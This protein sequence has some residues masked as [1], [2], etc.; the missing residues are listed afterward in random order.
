MAEAVEETKPPATVSVCFVVRNE[1][2]NLPRALAAVQGMADEVLVL[3]TGSCDATIEVARRHGARV[4][5]HLW[6]DD[7]AA[8]KNAAILEASSEWV[9]L[10]DADEE[11]DRASHDE[12]RRCVRRE[13]A[14]AYHILRE[15][16]QGDG[17]DGTEMRVLRLFRKRPGMHYVGRCHPEFEPPLETVAAQEGRRVFPSTIRLRHTGYLDQFKRAK[18]ERAAHLLALELKERPGR[19]YYLVEYGRSLLLLGDPRGHSILRE[20]TAQF[21]AWIE[22]PAPPSSMAGPLLEYLVITP[23]TLTGCHL[24][25]SA[26]HALAEKWFPRSA[27]LIWLRALWHFQKDEYPAAARLLETLLKMGEQRTYDKTISFDSRILGD[28]A[29]L[30][31]AV[32]LIREA[33]L[34]AAE[35]QLRAIRPGSTQAAAAARNLE[36]IGQL[37]HEGTSAEAKLRQPPGVRDGESAGPL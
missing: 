10:I 27:P 20:A 34:A 36:I 35:T 17:R 25:P 9:L 21:L 13:E 31:L 14:F 3:D 8:A 7:F 5:H 24:A 4:A 32:C 6:A 26:L 30:N 15:D 37:R 18:Q 29:R 1:E 12:L 2:K 23:P 16:L 11:L 22:Q 33:K 28:D 19:F